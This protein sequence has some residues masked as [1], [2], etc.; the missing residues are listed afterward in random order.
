MDPRAKIS[1]NL[2]KG[3]R[4]ID[5]CDLDFNK[6]TRCLL[7]QVK[8][9]TGINYFNLNVDADDGTVRLWIYSPTADRARMARLLV[10]VNFKQQIKLAQAEQKLKQMQ[11]DLTSVQSELVTGVRVE[12]TVPNHL[13]GVMIGKGGS[14]VKEVVRETEIKSIDLDGKGNKSVIGSPC[15][16]PLEVMYES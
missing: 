15:L 13:I 7:L 5:S 1:T 8:E 16:F 11:S 14:R 6:F 4:L 12:F 3:N 10:D 2:A 9:Q